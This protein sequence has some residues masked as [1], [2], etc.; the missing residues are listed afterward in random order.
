M[1]LTGR[2]K[3]TVTYAG[4]ERR[5]G[6]VPDGLHVY[7][8][9]FWVQTANKQLNFVQHIVALLKVGG[10]AAVVLPDNVLFEAGAAA[11]VCRRLLERCDLHTLLRLP[12]GLFYAQGV[13]ANVLFFSRPEKARPFSRLISVYD[14]RSNN[15]FSLKTRPLRREDLAEFV[16]LYR[17][18]DDPV[19]QSDRTGQRWRS[20]ERSAVLADRD[21]CLDLSWEFSET[22]GAVPSVARLDE[23]ANLIADDLR[24]ALSLIARPLSSK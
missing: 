21:C 5:S 6:K 20:F 8:P 15:R 11:T 4:G 12:T 13:K 23:L 24:R 14:L 22:A 10:R 1:W 16:E 9:D 18:S 7:R 17:D 2:L 3:G 19:R